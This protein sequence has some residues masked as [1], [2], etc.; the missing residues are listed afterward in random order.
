MAKVVHLGRS[1]S[2]AGGNDHPLSF[3]DQLAAVMK[4]GNIFGP[5]IQFRGIT[6]SLP[7]GKDYYPW[8][9]QVAGY[10]HGCELKGSTL[11]SPLRTDLVVSC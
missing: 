6:E 5:K 9:R 11:L 8:P 2:K 3:N 1:Y 10:F 4:T 7:K